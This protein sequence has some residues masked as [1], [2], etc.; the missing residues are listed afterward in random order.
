MLYPCA[1]CGGQQHTQGRCDGCGAPTKDLD[2][3]EHNR[4]MARMIALR[5][6]QWVGVGKKCLASQGRQK[7]PSGGAVRSLLRRHPP[8]G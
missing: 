2:Y 6:A 5:K 3:T 7:V 4:Q 1:Y 8:A